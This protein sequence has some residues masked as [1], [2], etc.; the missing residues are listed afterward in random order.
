MLGVGERLTTCRVPHTVDCFA[1]LSA[2]GVKLFGQTSV[3]EK[4]R[5]FIINEF[6]KHVVFLVN[7]CHGEV[8]YGFDGTCLEFV[9]VDGGIVVCSAEVS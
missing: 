1:C 4:F 2:T 9:L 3:F 8:D 7:E 5:F 6:L